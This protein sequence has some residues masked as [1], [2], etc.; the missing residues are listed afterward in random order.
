MGD[1]A[2]IIA[3]L[4]FTAQELLL[5]AAIGFII[6]GIDDLAIDFLWMREKLRGRLRPV[7]ASSLTPPCDAM[8][9]FIPAWDESSVIGAMLR[10]LSATLVECDLRIF[11][12]TYPND[13]ATIDA[14][15]DQAER[16]PRIRLVILPRF[17]PTTKADCLNVLW[18]AMLR[19]EVVAGRRFAGVV[20][21][22]AEDVAHPLELRV[23]GAMLAHAMAAQ[24]PVLPLVVPGSPL[25]SGHYCDEFVE[26]HGRSLPVRDALGAALPLAGVGCALRRDLLVAIAQRRG[27][28]PFDASS[29]TEDYELG[30]AVAREG[31]RARFARAVDDQGDPVAVRGYFPATINA[32][33]RQKSRWMTGI[34]LAG[35]DRTG[36]GDRASP[37]E[38]WM[39]MRD[40][41]AILAVITLACAYLGLLLS[42]VLFLATGAFGSIDQSPITWL[43]LATAF[44]LLW[45]LLWRSYWVAQSY[46]PLAALLVLPRLV[47]GNGIAM[48]AARRAMAQYIGLMRGKALRWDK[49]AH[50]FPSNAEIGA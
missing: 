47:V 37:I 43:L 6:G 20:M 31:G 12:G 11:V 41:R 30:L 9:I 29:L 27:G 4:G 10:H 25:I 22:D 17:G 33:V 2:W 18:Q 44:L 34:A 38:W 3:A 14:V 49:T 15:A 19:D 48:L 8:A 39:R 23:L 50:H 35:W 21:H 36:W 1:G 45:R 32:A 16:D 42:G 24:L 5:F 46:G 7:T 13:P 40:R 28:D 26:A